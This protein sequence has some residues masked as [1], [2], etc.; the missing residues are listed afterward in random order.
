MNG[1][2]R[3]I[4]NAPANQPVA[5]PL[6]TD[7]C[8]V[9]LGL[10]SWIRCGLRM[11]TGNQGKAHTLSRY[12]VEW[13]PPIRSLLFGRLYPDQDVTRQADYRVNGDVLLIGKSIKW[14]RSTLNVVFPKLVLFHR[15]LVLTKGNIQPCRTNQFNV[16][17]NSRYH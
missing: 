13:N 15:S 11:R 16:R 5:D 1:V 17:R 3:P 6:L 9:A 2:N 7:D 14:C 4:V 10:M 12:R 8:E